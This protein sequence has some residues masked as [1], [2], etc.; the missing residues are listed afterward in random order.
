MFLRHSCSVL[1]LAGIL[2]GSWLAPALAMEPSRRGSDRLWAESRDLPLVEN[3]PDLSKPLTRSDFI[4]S[5]AYFSQQLWEFERAHSAELERLCLDFEEK[6]RYLWTRIDGL[7]GDGSGSLRNEV[8]RAI[9]MAGQV[10]QRAEKRAEQ[11]ATQTKNRSKQLAVPAPY[12]GNADLYRLQEEF[13]LDMRLDDGSFQLDQPLTQADY[14]D[15]MRQ[16]EVIYSRVLFA[17]NSFFTTDPVEFALEN[18]TVINTEQSFS[19]I[20]DALGQ[21]RSHLTELRALTRTLNG[22]QADSAHTARQKSAVGS[23]AEIPDLT[24][25]DPAYGALEF[26]REI[27]GLG[28]LLGADGRFD[29]QAA[30]TRGEF[31]SYS[32]YL[33]DAPM[34][35]LLAIGCGFNSAEY[36]RDIRRSSSPMVDELQQMVRELEG[37]IADINPQ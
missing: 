34:V 25:A 24:P 31:V 33:I 13:G 8:A 37:A 10:A 19:D 23:V 5:T 11:R 22:K 12:N 26:F 30:L 17:G 3:A 20:F 2:V 29:G 32:L 14:L 21:V 28:E 9:E 35:S 7:N 1:A 36:I 27:T 16:L 6:E 4:I 18:Q 15:Y